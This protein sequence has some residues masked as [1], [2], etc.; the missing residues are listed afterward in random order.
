DRE[1]SDVFAI[2]EDIATAIAGA[3]RMPLGLAP[4][5]R[6]VANSAID[7]QS[8]EQYLRAMAIW[9]T[10]NQTGLGGN[11]FVGAIA[12]LED[13]VA[14][15]PGYAPAWS[16]LARMSDDPDKRKMAAQEAFRLDPRNAT[17]STM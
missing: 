8:Y 2:Q 14:R 16:L 9:R 4:G 7:P 13:A 10:R 1:L 12:M 17:Y 5:E 3:L 6:L 15:D 11:R